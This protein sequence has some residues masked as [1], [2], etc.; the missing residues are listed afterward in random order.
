MF[1]FNT[2]CIAQYLM[3]IN[4]VKNTKKKSHSSGNDECVTG[5]TVSFFL[6]EECIDGGGDPHT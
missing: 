3:S 4:V 1:L 2:I 6:M 5:T